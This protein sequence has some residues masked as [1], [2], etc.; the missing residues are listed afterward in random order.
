VPEFL[1][2]GATRSCSARFPIVVSLFIRP[3]Q[4]LWVL[5]IK[6]SF[7]PLFS[8][9]SCIAMQTGSQFGTIICK[10]S[11]DSCNTLKST[12]VQ[13]AQNCLNFESILFGGREE[14]VQRE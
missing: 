12:Y 4:L 10:A 13:P 7:I 1:H 14:A 6:E 9:L 5:A 8:L 3:L 11:V 2:A